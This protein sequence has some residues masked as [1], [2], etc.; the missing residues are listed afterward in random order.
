MPSGPQH[1]PRPLF[2]SGGTALNGISAALKQYTHNSVHLITPFDSGGSSQELR[3]AFDMPAVGDLR[4]RLVALADEGE[5][6]QRAARDL[7]SHRFPSD[8]ACSRLE[9]EFQQLLDGAHPLMADIDAVV[10]SQMLGML[11]IVAGNMPS[12]FDFRK[13]SVGNLILAGGYIAHGRELAP[14]LEWMSKTMGVLGTVRAIAD[15]NLQIGVK[16]DD[17]S[18]IIGQARF[19]GKETAPIRQAIRSMFLSDGTSE[20]SS[21]H[22]HLPMENAELVDTADLICYPPGSLFSSVIANLLVQGVGRAVAG[23]QVPKVYVP[24]L[25]SDPECFG[26]TLYD[27][28]AAIL[29]TLR[30]D[31]GAD[32][33]ARE[34]ISLVLTSEKGQT[35]DVARRL[36]DEHGI[37]CEFLDVADTMQPDRY[38]SER[39]CHALVSL[40]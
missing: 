17:G 3:R 35:G 23:R 26:M 8:A 39:L 24:S 31:A 15:V 16:L 32:C 2:F 22:V 33:P 13:A 25:G 5:K 4:S 34:L 9:S 36:S 40:M 21:E 38:D 14:V 30:R 37:S 18:R 19:T 6:A 1:G 11:A 27:Q 29:K 20:I 28:V 12:D 7:S 10:R